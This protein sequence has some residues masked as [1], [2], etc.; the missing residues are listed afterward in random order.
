[1]FI[2]YVLISVKL[3]FG[4]VIRL[5]FKLCNLICAYRLLEFCPSSPKLFLQQCI[6]PQSINCL[7]NITNCVKKTMLTFW[8]YFSLPVWFGSGVSRNDSPEKS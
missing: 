6:L 8:C 7:L 4:V 1:M 3:C 2:K 5:N